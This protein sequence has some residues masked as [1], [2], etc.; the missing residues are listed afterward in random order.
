[1]NLLSDEKLID[2]FT[3]MLIEKESARRLYCSYLELYEELQRK[4]IEF[5]KQHD[6]FQLCDYEEAYDRYNSFM[7]ESNFI[8]EVI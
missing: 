3:K 8:S 6:N 5:I 7:E 2:E 1:M 4:S